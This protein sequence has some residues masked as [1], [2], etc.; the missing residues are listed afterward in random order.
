MQAGRMGHRQLVFFGGGSGRGARV[1]LTHAGGDF[2]SVATAVLV[3]SEDGSVSAVRLGGAARRCQGRYRSFDLIVMS[4][5][6]LLV[7]WRTDMKPM[8][9]TGLLS[10]VAI[11]MVLDQAATQTSPLEQINALA[12]QS[13]PGIGEVASIATIR[14]SGPLRFLDSANTS[15]FLQLNGNPPSDRQYTL[16]PPSYKW[17]AVFSFDES[18]Y[19][20]D[21]EKI[22]SDDL[23]SSLKEGNKL[24]IE[25][26]RRLNLPILYLDGWSVPPHYDLQTKRLEWGT[27]LRGEDNSIVV[28]YS[29]R[30]LGRTGVMKAI[31]VTEPE[32]L[33]DDLREFRSALDGF[34][35]KS[36]YKYAEFRSGDKVAEYG[37]AALVLG[38]AAAVAAKSGAAKGLFK[39]IAV[40]AVAFGAA[41][42]AFIKRLFGRSQA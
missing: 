23:L 12:W 14:L 6:D 7:D 30:L 29:T 11:V 9:K 8:L 28:N 24:G 38:G 20:K 37:L 41:I 31:L 22:D 2:T 34:E 25:E 40:G 17:F 33:Q 1:S 27:R 39:L 5:V 32:A 26:R 13:A 36:G 15:R 16:A 42:L 10:V 21:D 19:V 3:I 35:F 4:I 18:G